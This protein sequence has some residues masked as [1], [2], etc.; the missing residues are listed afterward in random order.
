MSKVRGT[1]DKLSLCLTLAKRHTHTHH[2]MR[3][4][5]MNIQYILY[6]HVLRNQRLSFIAVAFTA[7]TFAL[8]FSFSLARSNLFCFIPLNSFR[9]LLLLLPFFLLLFFFHFISIFC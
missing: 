1:N 4:I 9:L 3:R 8:L 2:T 7:H 5:I 6:I